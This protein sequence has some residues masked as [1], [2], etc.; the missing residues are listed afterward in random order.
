V[1]GNGTYTPKRGNLDGENGD[2]PKGKCLFP[3]KVI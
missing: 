3:V 2:E 1:S